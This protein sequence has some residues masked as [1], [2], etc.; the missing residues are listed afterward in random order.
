MDDIIDTK[1]GVILSDNDKPTGG[2]VPLYRK[3][4]V[5]KHRPTTGV[6][7]NMVS[8]LDIINKKIQKK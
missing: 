4:G 8:I 1:S 7:P 5:A 6:K 3:S 2:F